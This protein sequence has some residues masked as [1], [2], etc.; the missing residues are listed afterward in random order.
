[1]YLAARQGEISYSAFHYFHFV[2]VD[3]LFW[4]MSAGPQLAQSRLTVLRIRYCP[5]ALPAMLYNA[6]GYYEMDEIQIFVI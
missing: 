5:M 1:M 3:Y 4:L 2:G 6:Q